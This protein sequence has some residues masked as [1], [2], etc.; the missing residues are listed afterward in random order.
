VD[1]KALATRLVS[2]AVL[3][4]VNRIGQPRLIASLEQSAR[5]FGFDSHDHA[6]G[7]EDVVKGSSLLQELGI[8][9]HVELGVLRRRHLHASQAEPPF[10]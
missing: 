1:R 4:L 6:V 3:T 10:S 8:R 2:F 9:G 7:V 5:P